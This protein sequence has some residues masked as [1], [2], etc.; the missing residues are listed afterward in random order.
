MMINRRQFTQGAAALSG[1][2]AMPPIPVSAQS[3]A[4]DAYSAMI[5]ELARVEEAAHSA[6]LGLPGGGAVSATG[7][8]LEAFIGH[9][10]LQVSPFET[11]GQVYREMR[12]F[13][14]D[15]AKEAN[16]QIRNEVKRLAEDRVADDHRSSDEALSKD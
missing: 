11:A 3:G 4:M 14:R 15:Q 12:G 1:A 6:G 5:S 9:M 13:L 7:R 8:K 16:Q 10:D 2:A